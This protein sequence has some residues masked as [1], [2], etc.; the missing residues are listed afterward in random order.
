MLVR[1]RTMRMVCKLCTLYKKYLKKIKVN[2]TR[3]EK[4]SKTILSGCSAANE[5]N[6]ALAHSIL[7]LCSFSHY[8][9][10]FGGYFDSSKQAIIFNLSNFDLKKM[11]T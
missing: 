6:I 8:V 9:S 4:I 5:Q 2:Y 1:I 10:C 3:E 7:F 11:H